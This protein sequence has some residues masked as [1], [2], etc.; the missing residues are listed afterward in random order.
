MDKESVYLT[1]DDG[2]HPEITVWILDFLKEKGLVATFFCVGANILKY[3]EVF[4]RIKEEGHQVGNHTMR[5]ENS[6]KTNWRNYLRSVKHC[7][8]LIG[9]QL[10]RPPYGRLSAWKS[11]ILSKHYN[12]IMWSWL[13]YDYDRNVALETIYE[14]AEKELKAGDILVLHDN[15]KVNDRVQILLP[16][17][18]EVIE[19]KGLKFAL[20][21]V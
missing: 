21:S 16:K 17:L 18:V 4:E 15:P 7:E 3:P 2:P 12:L 6:T 5:H 9:N 13:S 1:F 19:K 20:I 14:S 10:F 11:A 8:K